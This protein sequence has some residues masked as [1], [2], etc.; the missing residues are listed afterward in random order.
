[1]MVGPPRQSGRTLYHHAYAKLG[2]PSQPDALSFAA[3]FRAA[4]PVT[5][6]SLLT[7]KSEYLRH[8]R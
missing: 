5:I 1:M 4:K 8:P 2:M 7:S 6:G 3:L